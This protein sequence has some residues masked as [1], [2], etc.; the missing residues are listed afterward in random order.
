MRRNPDHWYWKYPD[1]LIM[2]S[3]PITT[4]GCY[5]KNINHTCDRSSSL[6]INWK[7]PQVTTYPSWH[8]LLFE[9]S[10]KSDKDCRTCRMYFTY[11]TKHAFLVNYFTTI[12]EIIKRDPLREHYTTS[13]ISMTRI[14][15]IFVIT[16]WSKYTLEID[17]TFFSDL[18]F[19][20]T[21]R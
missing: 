6:L 11:F 13:W 5:C 1:G 2:K 16:S 12:I 8:D 3:Y 7:F 21:I 4:T 19:P 9:I 20:K 10:K 18:I 14:V 15:Y 17:F